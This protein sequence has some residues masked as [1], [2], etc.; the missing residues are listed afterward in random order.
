MVAT[1][2]E[3]VGGGWLYTLAGSAGAPE[4]CT[5]FIR[6]SSH[7]LISFPI[8]QF[9]MPKTSEYFGYKVSITLLVLHAFIDTASSHLPG[10]RVKVM[11]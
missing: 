2:R 6:N 11:G 8:D 3:E 4:I 10:G 1:G 5:T 9:T 7:D